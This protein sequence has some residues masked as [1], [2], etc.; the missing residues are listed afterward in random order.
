MWNTVFCIWF[1]VREWMHNNVIYSVCVCVC[2]FSLQ[3]S[4]A[5]YSCNVSGRG[6]RH[7]NQSS[8]HG[9]CR[10]THTLHQG[11]CVFIIMINVRWHTSSHPNSPN[12]PIRPCWMQVMT[13]TT[14]CTPLL[15]VA[16]TTRGSRRSS[17]PSATTTPSRPSCCWRPEPRPTRTQWSVCRCQARNFHETL[18]LYDSVVKTLNKQVQNAN[19]QTHFGRTKLITCFLSPMRRS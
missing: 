14:C 11:V 6:D 1:I 10:R 19:D 7:W 17:S 18:H 15:A 5:S 2:V 9:C 8:T 4:E 13:P 3:S 12:S 16:M